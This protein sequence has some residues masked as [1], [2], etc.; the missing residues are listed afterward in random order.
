MHTSLSLTPD[1]MT[2]MLTKFEQLEKIIYQYDSLIDEWL[3]GNDVSL[4]ETDNN[5][6][7]Y[8]FSDELRNTALAL[9]SN[10]KEEYID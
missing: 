4:Y 7:A 3:N 8:E 10:L 5:K 2:D 9:I 6:S 1:G